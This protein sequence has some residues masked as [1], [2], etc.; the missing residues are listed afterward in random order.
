MTRDRPKATDSNWTKG[1]SSSIRQ[2]DWRDWP[3]RLR[4]LHRL[5]H[6]RR[7]V[8][9]R[10]CRCGSNWSGPNRVSI[11]PDRHRQTT[12]MT[13]TT[14]PDGRHCRWPRKCG[15]RCRYS[16][17]GAATATPT[18]M[19]TRT[20]NRNGRLWRTA[21]RW[22]VKDRPCGQRSRCWRRDLIRRCC[23]WRR[24]CWTKSE[25]RR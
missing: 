5:R 12:R 23:S 3:N 13:T 19:T 2:Q 18:K 20:M 22:A 1:A 6:H 24:R 11:D 8:L 17:G 25:R 10:Y 16:G 15:R 7:H 4:R 14:P 9:R 21:A